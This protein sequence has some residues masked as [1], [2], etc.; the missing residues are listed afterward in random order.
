MII[1]MTVKI[2]SE[3]K[4][5]SYLGVIRRETD[6]I[7]PI[8][9]PHFEM[10]LIDLEECIQPNLILRIDRSLLNDCTLQYIL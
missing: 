3:E 7:F 2:S 9:R 6:L 10:I 4:Y 5:Y 8:R 1:F